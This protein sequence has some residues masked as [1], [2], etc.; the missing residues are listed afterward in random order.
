M[1][2]A[3]VLGWLLAALTGAAGLYCLA[4]LCAP[5]SARGGARGAAARESD[6]AAALM[7][8]GMAVLALPPAH[9]GGLPPVAWAAVFAG[10]GAWFT[11][12]ALRRGGPGSRAHRLHH[13]VDAGAMV[14][15]VLLMAGPAGHPGH[16]AM[17]GMTGM[18]NA[19]APAVLAL[20][21]VPLV[22]GL[23]L[24]YFGGYALWTGTRL[25]RPAHAVA[26][27][28]GRA[29][30]WMPGMSRACRL[31]MGLGMFSMLLAG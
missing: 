24:L 19:P 14:Y 12:A 9:Q 22:S 29:L 1:H 21:P 3:P 5:A 8:L 25:L 23:L 6:A 26:G 11:A 30:L 16:G 20:D 4:R 28:G 27:P 15:M 18:T 2:G 10:A 7:G 13:A 31:V 17:A